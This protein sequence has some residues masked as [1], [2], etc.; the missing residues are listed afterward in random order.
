MGGF[1]V[2]VLK[3]TLKR[4]GNFP[5]NSVLPLV[6]Y[7]KAFQLEKQDAAE[8]VKK[9]FLENK[10]YR[11]WVNGIYDFHHFH[12][13]NHEVLAIVEGVCVVCFGGDDHMAIEVQKGDVIILPAGVAHKKIEC[14]KDF[15]CVGAYAVDIEYDMMKGKK[16]LDLLAE[17][18]QLNPLPQMDPV[19]GMEGPLLKY[20]KKS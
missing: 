11:P 7:K 9:I 14:S 10:W 15:S 13:N 20:W 8:K 5:N 18:I 17:R 2:K 1:M 3:K 6:I 16:A 19:F 12:S 4:N